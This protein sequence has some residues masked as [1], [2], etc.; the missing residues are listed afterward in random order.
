MTR[1]MDPEPMLEEE[2]RTGWGLISAWVFVIALLTLVGYMLVKAQKG[3]ASPGEPAPNFTL[4]SFDGQEYEL[5]KLRGKVVLINIWASWCIPCEAEAA[6]LQAAW[7]YYQDR[8]D[9]I[10]LGIDYADTETEALAFLERF[11]ITYPNGPDLGTRI[12]TAYNA[13]G[14]PETFIIDQDGII[15]FV[16]IGAFETTEDIIERIDPLL[17]NSDGS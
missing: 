1:S 9:V 2:Q 7:E 17:R 3:I 12:Y 6:E 11:G 15:S 8:G 14:V 5:S 10:F 13:L 16:M 4:T